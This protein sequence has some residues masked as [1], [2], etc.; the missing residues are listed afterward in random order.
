VPMP[1]STIARV[2]VGIAAAA[3]PSISS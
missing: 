2:R 1:R 3:T